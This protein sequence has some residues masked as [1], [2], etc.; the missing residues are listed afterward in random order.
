MY[1]HIYIYVQ[2]RRTLYCQGPLE[3]KE[4]NKE[5]KKERNKSTY[6]S[7]FTVKGLQK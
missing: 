5:R 3:K 1:I 2:L 6:S 4:R 7:L